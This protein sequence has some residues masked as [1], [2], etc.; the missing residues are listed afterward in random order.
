M[1]LYEL[2]SA[3]YNLLQKVEFDEATDEELYF[4]KNIFKDILHLF[5]EKKI[6]I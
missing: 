2:D 4:L 6:N 1:T 3:L 5:A